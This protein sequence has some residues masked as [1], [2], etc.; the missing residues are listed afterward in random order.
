MKSR[1]AIV[2]LLFSA[3]VQA[4]EASKSTADSVAHRVF[5]VSAGPAWATARYFAFTFYLDRDGKAVASFPQR[6][7]RVTGDYRVSGLDPQGKKFEVIMNVGTKTGKA[8]L[9][10][11]EVTGD[12][13]APVLTLGYRRYQNDIFWLLMQF[14]MREQGVRRGYAGTRDDACGHTWDVIEPAF[15]ASFGFSPSDQYSVWVNRDSGLI[16]YWDMK[17]AGQGNA[18]TVTFRDY[19]RAGGLLI[20][21]RREIASKKQTVRLEDLQVLPEPPKGAFE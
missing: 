12:K 21:T 5:E 3:A 10:G 16:D 20:S 9:D 2:L 4:Q 11:A 17:L 15:D 14:K 19:Q 18:V 7:D 8:W 13:L 6:F 1:F